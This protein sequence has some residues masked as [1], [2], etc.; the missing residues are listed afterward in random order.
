MQATDV[1]TLVQ[2][3]LS[4]HPGL[5]LA[6]LFGSAASGQMRTDSDVDVAVLADAP[7]APHQHIQL[8]GDLAQATGR[9]IDLVDL[10]TT[11]EPLLGQILTH[12]R[13]LLGSTDAHAALISRH[14]FDTADFLPYA[15]RMIQ[16]RRDAWIGR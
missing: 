7:L 14:W 2:D 16:E 8:I 5:R 11:G 9:A 1:F 3:A 4:R 13:K 6:L 12:G 10:S 15:Q